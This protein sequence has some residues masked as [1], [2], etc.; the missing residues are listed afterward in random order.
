LGRKRY[1]AAI[2]M[3]QQTVP[4]RPSV[5]VVSVSMDTRTWTT[6]KTT[7]LTW[8]DTNGKTGFA[9]GTTARYIRLHVTKGVGPYIALNYIRVEGR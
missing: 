5:V 4:T 7:N 2:T 6:L 8:Y 9:V 3:A 1:A